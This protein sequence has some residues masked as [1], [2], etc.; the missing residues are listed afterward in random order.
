V[1]VLLGAHLIAENT[2]CEVGDIEAGKGV[3]CVRQ[4]GWMSVRVIEVG[5]CGF[6]QARSA[7]AKV[8][9]D[10]SEFLGIAR[11][12]VKAVTTGGPDAAGGFGDP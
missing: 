7:G 4:Q 1:E 10:S 2:V 11:Y 9:G 8:V 5:D 6:D 12:E 3:D